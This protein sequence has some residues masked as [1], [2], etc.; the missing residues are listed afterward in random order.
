MH[1]KI[2]KMF[3]RLD[4]SLDCQILIYISK[5]SE[6]ILHIMKV[7]VKLNFIEDIFVCMDI[8]YSLILNDMYSFEK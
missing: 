6:T 8:L 4:H 7:N 3:Y 1:I 2:S 5:S